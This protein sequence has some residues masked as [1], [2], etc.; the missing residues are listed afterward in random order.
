MQQQN[1]VIILRFLHSIFY[2]FILIENEPET[3]VVKSENSVQSYA[4]V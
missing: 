1:T 4:F 3:V 2:C